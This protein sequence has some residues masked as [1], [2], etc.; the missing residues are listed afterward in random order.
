MYNEHVTRTRALNFDKAN[1]AANATIAG[2]YHDAWDD[3]RSNQYKGL[4][5]SMWCPHDRLIWV[6]KIGALTNVANTFIRLGTDANNYTEWRVIDS[7]L[8]ASSWNVCDVQ[9]GVPAA[10]VGKGLDPRQ[11]QYLAF[12]VTFDAEANALTDIILDCVYLIAAKR[13]F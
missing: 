10:Q 5:L 4:D 8:D 12:G 6:M 1:T 13:T 2:I 3:D 7:D 9:F 11:L